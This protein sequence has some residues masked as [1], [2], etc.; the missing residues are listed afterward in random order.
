MTNEQAV[1]NET[2][3]GVIR[4]S[5]FKTI[6]FGGL[7]VGILDFFDAWLFFGVYV[8]AGFLRVWQGV[9]SGLLGRDAAVAG[10]LPTAL[11]GI[12]L[13]FIVAFG[14]ATVYYFLASRI[15]FMLRQPVVTG[16][17]YGVIVH[18]VM[19]NV[20]VPLSAIGA[21]APYTL[22][23]ALNSFIGHAL[24]VGLPVALIASWSARRRD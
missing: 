16:L 6:I 18:L 21:N 1:S 20:V 5:A 22:P 14:V 13:H 10:G 3:G 8:G 19:R 12:L 24:L 15:Q 11:I 23:N 4:P 9:A 7:T 2:G 17:I